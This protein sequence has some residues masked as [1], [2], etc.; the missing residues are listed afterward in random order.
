MGCK[1]AVFGAGRARI[2]APVQVW[3]APLHQNASAS[4]KAN[5]GPGH[6]VLPR[7]DLHMGNPEGVPGSWLQAAR[8]GTHKEKNT[9]K[10]VQG[11]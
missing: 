7:P 1:A 3:D 4:E 11:D 2:G 8:D 5:D 9:R 6:W 10:L